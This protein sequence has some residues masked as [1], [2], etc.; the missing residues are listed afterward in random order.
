MI[1]SPAYPPFY[2]QSNNS[3]RLWSLTPCLLLIYPVSLIHSTCLFFF[4]PETWLCQCLDNVHAQLEIIGNSETLL[5]ANGSCIASGK[6]M[7]EHFA[8]K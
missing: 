1:P 3:S 2:C 7:K 4:F 5:T 6:L 8:F